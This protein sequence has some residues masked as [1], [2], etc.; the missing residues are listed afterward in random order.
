M[1]RLYWLTGAPLR[2]TDKDILLLEQLVARHAPRRD[3]GPLGALMLGV[4]PAVAAMSWPERS[5]LLA[6][7]GSFAMVK[8]VWPGDLPGARAAVCGGWFSLPFV[9]HS[10][11]VITGDGSANCVSFPEGLRELAEETHRVLRPSGCLFLRCY[12]Q[13]DLKEEPEHVLAGLWDGGYPSFHDF[14]F[15]FLMS[16]QETACHGVAVADVH[17][18]W[19][20]S[21]IDAERLASAT[22]WDRAVIGALDAYRDSPTVH[23]FPTLA[24]FRSVLGEY[25]EEISCS[26]ATYPLAERCPV[27]VLKRL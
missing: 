13:P 11:E 25:F 14:K 18:R 12:T 9:N 27:L 26:H 20:K 16:M 22:G 7:D 24:E 2:P 19:M 5:R 23:V 6:V 8:G 21:G 17:R 15:R 1:A 10:F 4:T 3:C